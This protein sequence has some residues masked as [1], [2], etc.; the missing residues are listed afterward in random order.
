MK[1]SIALVAMCAT[2]LSPVISTATHA[3][4][5]ETPVADEAGTITLGKMQTACNLIA[6]TNYSGPDKYTAV[7]V[8]ST[9]APALVDGP[10]ERTGTRTN[11][12]NVVLIGVSYSNFSISDGPFRVGGSVNMF[13]DLTA[14]Q[15]NWTGS[16]YD[17]QA[18]ADST[19]DFG[20]D[21]DILRAEYIAPIT[22]P[23]GVYD[24][25]GRGDCNGFTPD[26]D[27]W[28]EDQGACIFKPDGTTISVGAASYGEP[29]FF[30]TVDGGAVP[31][32]QDDLLAG[33]EAAG[34]ADFATG[35]F[36][37]G[38]V[39]ICISPSTTTKRGSP[40]GWVAKNYYG[41]GDLNGTGI[42]CNATTFVNAAYKSGSETSQGTYN[43]VP[44]Y[45]ELTTP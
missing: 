41:G 32:P 20:F 6:S 19:F 3:A 13:G 42:G 7:A 44:G 18:I 21:C 26:K 11:F 5:T 22:K 10:T 27:F 33:H 31:Q 24:N 25:P 16:T 28:G 40:G 12:T 38:Q 4:I 35:N 15:K 2:A 17:Y 29:E 34:P 9:D 36:P 43:S 14:G 8:P 1:K 37:Q 45:A 39:V 30:E 23:G